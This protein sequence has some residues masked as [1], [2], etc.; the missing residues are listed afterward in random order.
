[1]IEKTPPSSKKSRLV[2][3]GLLTLPPESRVKSKRTPETDLRVRAGDKE[4]GG[5]ALRSAEVTSLHEQFFLARV[6]Q[7]V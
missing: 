3:T 6:R 7:L 1:M 2:G 5:A 4:F